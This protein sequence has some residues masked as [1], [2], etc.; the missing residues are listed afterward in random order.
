MSM[1]G[2]TSLGNFF[3]WSHLPILQVL[4]TRLGASASQAGLLVSA[5]GWGGLV[6]SLLVTFYNPQRTG[7]LYTGGIL[8]ATV[9]LAGATIPSFWL[10]FAALAA[11]GFGAGL[12]GSVQAS[13][14]M[15]M[16]PD[17]L[18]GRALGILTLAIGAAPFGCAALGELAEAQGAYFAVR[19]FTAVGT[20]AQVLWLSPCAWPG[21]MR[22]RMSM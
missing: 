16:V 15:N 9:L 2:V 1:L 5:S 19:M 18:R 14:V 20:V 22:I 6:A 11:S 17:E 7:Y 21:A 12:F 3:Y 4:A 13:L 8:A 10:A